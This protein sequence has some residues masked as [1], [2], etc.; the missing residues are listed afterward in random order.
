MWKGTWLKLRDKRKGEK[1]ILLFFN[2]K[3]KVK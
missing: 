1:I 3:I 2:L